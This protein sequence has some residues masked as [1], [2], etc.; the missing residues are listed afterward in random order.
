MGTRSRPVALAPCHGGMAFEFEEGGFVA[1]SA[2]VADE[3]AVGTDDTVAGDEDAERVPADGAADG[4]RGHFGNAAPAGDGGG[5]GPVGG[6]L[7]EGHREQCVHHVAAER[8][9][10]VD[11][12]RRREVRLAT[13][14]VDVEPASRFAKGRQVADRCIGAWKRRVARAFEE[15]G[16]ED[17][18]VGDH[19]Q[20]VKAI[21]RLVFAVEGH[22]GRHSTARCAGQ[23]KQENGNCIS[24]RPSA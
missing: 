3:G 1:E 11:A 20:V 6:R 2:A 14:K 12:V 22:G 8:R 10:V 23:V 7:S 18:P 19:P 5:D 15:Q 16:C 24:G 4:L 17:V 9:E 13:G 21:G